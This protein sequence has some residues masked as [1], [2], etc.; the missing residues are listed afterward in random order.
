MKKK[1]KQPPMLMRIFLFLIGI[2]FIYLGVMPIVV[3]F[4]GEAKPA[5]ITS[6]TRHGGERNDATPGNYNYSMGYRFTTENGESIDGFAT[7][8]GDS[9]YTK[10]L[11]TSLIEVS[12]LPAMPAI[13]FLKAD[14]KITL[15]LPIYLAIGGLLCTLMVRT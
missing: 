13:N 1:P 10:A 9:V 14:T 15:R 3:G 8:V 12:Y 2:G 7:W 4:V 6:V 5:L 11:G